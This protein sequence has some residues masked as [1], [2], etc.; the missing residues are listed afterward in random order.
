MNAGLV[1]G[2]TEAERDAPLPCDELEPDAVIADR[3]ISIAAPPALVFAWLCQ[4][5]AATYSYRIGNRWKSSPRVR[6]PQL[7]E[8]AVGQRFMGQF[9]LE[10]FALGRH[11]TLRAGDICVTYAVRPEGAGTRLVVRVRFGGSPLVGR[12]LALGDVI[13]MRKQLRT[14]KELAEAE[15]ASA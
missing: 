7:T 15:A 2:A 6:D 4:L 10:S 12:V 14:L 1:W 3:A 9:D 11:V 8:L 13:M 5:R